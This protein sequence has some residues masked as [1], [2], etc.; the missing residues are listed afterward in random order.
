MPLG[1][2]VSGGS[3][4]G[5]GDGR[6]GCKS[7]RLGEFKCIGE[8]EVMKIGFIGAGNIAKTYLDVLDRIEDAQ[9]TA[10]CT[11][12]RERAGAVAQRMKY[13]PDLEERGENDERM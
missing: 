8:E 2:F 5:Q 3:L 13:F 12:H 10:V 4:Q 1:L 9:I 7:R 6:Q 11:I